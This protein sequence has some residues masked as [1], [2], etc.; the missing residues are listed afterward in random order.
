MRYFFRISDGHP[1][2]DEIGEEL[3]DDRH[4][5]RTATRLTRDIENALEPNGCLDPDVSRPGL[6]HQH[7]IA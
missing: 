5:W 1:Y 7:Q 4:A 2:H 6:L 3:R